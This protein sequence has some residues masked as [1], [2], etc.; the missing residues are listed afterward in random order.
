M[1]ETDTL[2]NAENP[3][4]RDKTENSAY[5]E[6]AAQRPFI[7]HVKAKIKHLKLGRRLKRRWDHLL[8]NR[9]TRRTGQMMIEAGRWLAYKPARKSK[10]FGRRPMRRAN[11][12][13]AKMTREKFM[14]VELVT[15]DPS[16][17]VIP[18]KFTPHKGEHPTGIWQMKMMES[19]GL[20]PHH[21]LLDIGC[22]DLKAG[23]LLLRY[24]D[25]GC[26]AGLDQTEIAIQQGCLS[27]TEDDWLKK[28]K[29]YLGGDFNFESTG[30]H[31][32][33][34]LA[35]SVFTHLDLSMVGHGLSSAY[36][37]LVPGGRF[38]ATFFAAP[39]DEPWVA[40][41]LYRDEGKTGAKSTY[42]FRN[43]F[44]HPLDIILVIGEG[45]GYQVKILD[46]EHPKT[47]TVIQFTRP[48]GT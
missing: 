21:S 31:F 36:A 38:I 48:M 16:E 13:K 30:R 10:G 19:M 18:K 33:F 26:Y 17:L 39:K 5:M 37:A 47:Q 11:K 40:E 27:I 1:N 15:P 29:F 4:S 3:E 28:P 24:L 23:I 25:V 20:K 12:G 14:P 6:K 35:N 9:M 34:M 32:D 46:L 45:I 2:E 42:S 7:Y 44:H 8:S 22:G 43:P 41:K